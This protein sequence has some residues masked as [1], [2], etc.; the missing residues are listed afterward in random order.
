[1]E[2]CFPKWIV[3][4]C[5]VA[6]ILLICTAMLFADP[7]AKGVSAETLHGITDPLAARMD[8][9]EAENKKLRK[10][11]E[12]LQFNFDL[13]AG[14]MDRFIQTM[15]VVGCKREKPAPVKPIVFAP[16]ITLP[17]IA[18]PVIAPKLTVEVYPTEIVHQ[19]TVYREIVFVPCKR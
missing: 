12:D 2:S 16:K 3:P 8:K 4:A 19:P 14:R 9:L 13:V 17:P 6:I 15:Q 10:E 7:R 11:N 5:C 18:F 1:M